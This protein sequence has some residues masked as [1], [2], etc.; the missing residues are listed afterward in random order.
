[1]RF[2]RT[3]KK[4]VAYL[5]SAAL[6]LTGTAGYSF[7]NPIFAE[8]LEGYTYTDNSWLEFDK[9]DGAT[10]G[11]L[12]LYAGKWSDGQH[13]TVGAEFDNANPYTLPVDVTDN[14]ANGDWLV[15]VSFKV[16]GL[17]AGTAYLI[18]ISDGTNTVYE[19]AIN[20]TATSFSKIVDVNKTLTVGQ[21]TL[22]L[23]AEE[24]QNQGGEVE[25]KDITI[26][27]DT[28]NIA[29]NYNI[30]ANWTNPEG[31]T[32]AYAYLE[33]V[34]EGHS[35]ALLNNAWIFNEAAG[36]PMTSVDKVG[37]TKD[38]SIKVVM[39]GTYKLIVEAYNVFN[40]KIGYGEK[41]ITIPN[42]DVIGGDVVF[43]SSSRDYVTVDEN[44]YYA[45]YADWEAV[46]GAS[47]YKSYINEVAE[48][49]DAKASNGWIW[50]DVSVA[51][52][53]DKKVDTVWT[54]KDGSIL[55]DEDTAYTLIVIA[56]DNN[57]DEIGRGTVEFPAKNGGEVESTTP[58]GEVESTTPA[59]EVE[60][61]TPAVEPTNCVI[62][63]WATIGEDGW[64][65]FI[66][67]SATSATVVGGTSFEDGPL[68]DV[69][70][71]NW[72]EYDFQ[73]KSPLYT[74]DKAG[75]YTIT[76]TNI[77]SGDTSQTWLVVEDE[78][79]NP[80][81]QTEQ[82]PVV[83]GGATDYITELELTAGAQ[84]RL[85]YLQNYCAG[86]TKNIS[87]SVELQGSEVE[88]TTPAE[89]VETTTPSEVVETTTPSEVVETTT[90]SE[91][92]E[93]TTPSEVVETTTPSEVVETTT[94]AEV[95]ETTT[96][97]GG[98]NNPTQAPTTQA[99]TTQ[100]PATT[101]AP[102]TVAP[103]TTAPATTAAVKLAKGKIAKAS[104]AKNGKKVKLTFKKI[105][106]ATSYEIK[107]STSKK[108]K[109]GTKTYT[110]KKLSKTIKKL[111]AYKKYYVKVRAVAVAKD[112]TVTN[113]KWS[114]VKT[115]KVKK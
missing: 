17:T 29:A 44:T 64:T 112:G 53:T 51:G 50:N 38:G 81:A 41:N 1:M 18:K 84:I 70:K 76:L 95:V 61:T 89:V 8:A 87:A 7:N 15:Q 37:Q 30:W 98:N 12:G 2:N 59:G 42:P 49:K 52:S 94:P 24:I 97:A 96:P 33:Q 74:V 46:P 99:P 108:F 32:K 77:E 114:K 79:G 47:G 16:T 111:V 88:T 40:Q 26:T 69:V 110:T 45:L 105:K 60:S 10:E 19:E 6:V 13:A 106:G 25:V 57:G 80:L 36:Q 48:G 104:R 43:T 62:E 72:W 82:K 63:S 67:S 73:L 56:C 101:V 55:I 91:V 86:G 78:N 4:A 75:T 68:F 113:G 11:F 22:T 9:T 20:A 90:P 14:T 115:I 21:K 54:T 92:V 27:P 71:N 58:A 66:N 83:P 107:I 100:A 3:M 39:G 28:A 103:T 23:T 109:K 65:Y 85:V 93:T 35:A 102:T 34:D 31:T 5:C